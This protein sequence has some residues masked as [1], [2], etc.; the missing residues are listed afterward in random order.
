VLTPK[1]KYGK[2]N[3]SVFDDDLRSAFWH[4]PFGTGILFCL[5]F[6]CSLT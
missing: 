6:A 5:P 4:S 2:E 3:I 1:K